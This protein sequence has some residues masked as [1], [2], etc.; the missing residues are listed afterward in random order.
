MDRDQLKEVQAER[1]SVYGGFDDHAECVDSIMK[2]LNK[3]HQKKN[4]GKT[5]YPKGF[6]TALF[7]IVSKLVRLAT[8]PTHIDT[9]LDLS[10]YA[11]L[12]L[13]IIKKVKK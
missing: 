1:G 3:V 8:T 12:W 13:K 11:D 10:S 9:A 5:S 4:K 2:A 7:Y 6:R